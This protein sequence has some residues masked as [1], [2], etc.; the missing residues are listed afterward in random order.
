LKA[1]VKRLQSERKAD[2]KRLKAVVK[3]MQS[4]C[5]AIAKRLQS[6]CKAI[7]K[8]LQSDCQF[9][10]YGEWVIFT[11]TARLHCGLS[12]RSL[13]HHRN[14]MQRKKIFLL[15]FFIH[16]EPPSSALQRRSVQALQNK[17]KY[18]PR[19]LYVSIFSLLSLPQI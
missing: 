9:Q 2:V 13:T 1:I 17:R 3:R 6:D 8:R 12:L 11:L 18:H 14:A 16:S 7:A 5:K 10:G 15:Y 19:A 4:N